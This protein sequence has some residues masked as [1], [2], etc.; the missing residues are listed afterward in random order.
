MNASI[1][2]EPHK[3]YEKETSYKSAKSHEKLFCLKSHNHTEKKNMAQINK[4]E[5]DNRR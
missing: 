1:W 3:D 4:V 5:Q 2:M